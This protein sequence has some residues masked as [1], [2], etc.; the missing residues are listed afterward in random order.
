M[1]IS[2]KLIEKFKN[3]V[4]SEAFKDVDPSTVSN[5]MLKS[6]MEK[7]YMECPSKN[8]VVCFGCGLFIKSN[9]DVITNEPVCPFCSNNFSI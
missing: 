9:M 7:G 4:L 8:R 1:V 2:D 6:I 5:D 3:L